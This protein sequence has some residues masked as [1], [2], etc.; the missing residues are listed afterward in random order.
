MKKG[1]VVFH[2]KTWGLIIGR[3]CNVNATAIDLVDCE[4]VFVLGEP[5]EFNPSQWV[6]QLVINIQFHFYVMLVVAVSA[7]L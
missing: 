1:S 5:L 4:Y 2:N 6:R 7:Q 3:S